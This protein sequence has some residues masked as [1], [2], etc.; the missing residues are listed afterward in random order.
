MK[1]VN[2]G[3]EKTW[4]VILRLALPA[5]AAQIVN[6]LYSIVDK[7]YVGQ[8]GNGPLAGIGVCAP[9][10]TALSAFAFWISLGGGPLFSMSLGE[11]REDNA[12]K[13]LANS[14]LMLI[15]FA[16]ILDILA[17]SL[18]KPMLY[19][20]GASSHSYI[21]AKQYLQIYLIG[22]VFAILS[23]GL[24]EFLTAQGMSLEAML[25]TLAAC[26]LNIGLD[27][28]FMFVAKMGIEGAA[29]AT[30]LC[31]FVSFVV[32]LFLLLRKKTP[33]RLSFGSYDI[34]LMGKILKLG[35]SPF[36]I[37]A[38]DSFLLIAYNEAFQHFGSLVPSSS[39]V[40]I[41]GENAS[42]NS[43]GDF[44]IEVNTIVSSFESLVTGPLLGISTGTQPI[45]AYNYGA[46][47]EGLIKKSE[48]QIFTFAIV[49]TA[50][51]FALSYLLERP[52]AELF[53]RFQSSAD[54][55]AAYKEAIIE[56][57]VRYIQVYMYVIVPLSLQYV[58]VDGLTGMGQ[59]NTSIWLSINRKFF[60]MLPA[61]FLFPLLFQAM[62][63][64]AIEVAE[65]S[66]YAEFVADL[67]SAIVSTAVYF[68]VLPK[69][70]KKRM[71]S[72]KKAVV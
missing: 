25:S 64:D 62:G 42:E 27:P 72:Q 66:F 65:S 56:K 50:V 2:L 57:S 23:L 53:I 70:L 47:R 5:M 55:S 44:L 15:V 68:F 36:I 39:L 46:K 4:P 13:I 6:V 34:K 35:F 37:L 3:S 10:T 21:Y 17:Y 58:T 24:N 8:L 69:I 20:F 19:A 40:P 16:L 11:K 29:L 59:A 32:S 71:T 30:I 26:L 28:L 33:I 51:C 54:A 61:I 48:K 63:K 1:S 41:F 18:M 14:F 52:F 12:K 9:V 60:V 45:L 43:Y 38:T 67:A 31:Q 49:F 22:L 7:I